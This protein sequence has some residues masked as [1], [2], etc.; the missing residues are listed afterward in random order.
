MPFGNELSFVDVEV[1]VENRLDEEGKAF[2]YLTHNLAQERLVNALGAAASAA[3]QFALRYVQDRRVSDDRWDRSKT[4][5]SHSPNVPRTSTRSLDGG[6]CAR[7]SRRRSVDDCRRC[8]GQAVLHRNRRNRSARI[9][10]RT[11][12]MFGS[13]RSGWELLAFRPRPC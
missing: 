7:T 4:L 3:L 8:Q 2:S 1:T 9:V 11:A 13:V 12:A 6:H 10:F 5:S